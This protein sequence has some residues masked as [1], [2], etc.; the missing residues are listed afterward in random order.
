[1]I[2]SHVPVLPVVDVL[3]RALAR[4]EAG[5]I[6][7]VAVIFAGPD[8]EPDGEFN[9]GDGS[10]VELLGAVRLIGDAMSDEIRFPSA[11]DT[12]AAVTHLRSVPT[13]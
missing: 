12:P 10:L 11:D 5:E 1:M 8:L 4:A 9:E 7:A 6:N 3:R 2:K 13:N